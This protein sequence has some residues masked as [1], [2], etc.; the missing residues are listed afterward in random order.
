MGLLPI[1]LWMIMLV[2]TLVLL[3]VAAVLGAKSYT[4]A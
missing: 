3:P 2:V 1:N 4:E